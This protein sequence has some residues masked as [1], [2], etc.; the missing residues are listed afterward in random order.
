[1]D[2]AAP[3][4]RKPKSAAISIS[5]SR[6]VNRFPR[7]TPPVGPCIGISARSVPRMKRTRNPGRSKN[8]GFGF[9]T[10]RLRVTALTTPSTVPTLQT[11]RPIC[12]NGDDGFAVT[13]FVGGAGGEISVDASEWKMAGFPPFVVRV[14]KVHGLGVNGSHALFSCNAVCLHPML[15]SFSFWY[16]DLEIARDAHP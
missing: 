6:F 16:D 10:S 14:Q 2:S 7:Q 1:M 8:P 11:P 3:P 9:A 5:K 13:D 12:L 15:R 4:S